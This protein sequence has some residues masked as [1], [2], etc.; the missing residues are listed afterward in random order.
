MDYQIRIKGHLKNLIEWANG[1][2]IELE[3][4]GNTT[5]T[6]SVADQA[7]LYG[8][9]KKINDLGMTLVS[10]TPIKNDEKGM[11]K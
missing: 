10:I 11:E 5:L 9:L 2:S 6:G 7:A 1:L 3:Y 8:L 4:D